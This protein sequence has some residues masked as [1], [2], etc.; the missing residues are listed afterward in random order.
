M[1]KQLFLFLPILL[2]LLSPGCSS[3]QQDLPEFATLPCEAE[4]YPGLQGFQKIMDE[5]G[6]YLLA[7]GNVDAG[8]PNGFWKFYFPDGTL[9]KEGNY[10]NGRLQGFWKLYYENGNL[11]E[12]GHYEDCLRNGFW[13]VYSES[14]QYEVLF[15][16][17]FDL[18]EINRD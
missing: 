11:R 17:N 4:H 16:G 18:G 13:K 6:S 5:T 10:T 8:V 3:P 15:E 12:E 2:C 1:K 9:W 14:K 7:E